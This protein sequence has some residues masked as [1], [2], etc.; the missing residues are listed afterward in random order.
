MSHPFKNNKKSFAALKALTARK[1]KK[2]IVTAPDEHSWWLKGWL[3]GKEAPENTPVLPD[4]RSLFFEALEPRILMS[5]DL[6]YADLDNAPTM[7]ATIEDTIS[8]ISDYVASGISTNFTLKVEDGGANAF[9]KLY[10]NGTDISPINEEIL[11]WEIN[12]ISDLTVNIQRDNLG[13]T[14]IGGTGLSLSDIIGD[15]LTIDTDSLGLLNGRFGGNA[16]NINFIGGRDLDLLSYFN[17]TLPPPLDALNDQMILSDDS[18]SFGDTLTGHVLNIHSSS[19]IVNDAT[20]VQITSA[21][22]I[23]IKSDSAVTLDA[24]SVLTGPNIKLWANASSAGGLVGGLLANASSTVTL[25]SA[26]LITNGGT[27][28]VQLLAWSTVAFIEHGDTYLTMQRACRLP[29]LRISR[30]S[31]I[32]PSR[33]TPG[34]F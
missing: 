17:I 16:V 22:D 33:S 34:R 1:N 2:D 4:T 13:L 25:D 14:D 19:D 27:G 7:G 28:T 8:N 18:N 15:K 26:S 9:W 23:A 31:R 32:V 3:R 6:T 30:S 29:R 10:A 20:G 5:A 24:G 12:E 21:Q 11:D